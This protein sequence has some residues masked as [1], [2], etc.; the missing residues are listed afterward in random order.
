V[1]SFTINTIDYCIAVE[2]FGDGYRTCL[3]RRFLYIAGVA[4]EAAAGDHSFEIRVIAVEAGAYC[5]RRLI[6][7]A[8]PGQGE[9]EERVLFP[10]GI[11]L[12]FPAGSEGD[13][14]GCGLYSVIERVCLCRGVVDMMGLVGYAVAGFY[15]YHA[16]V[17]E[18]ERVFQWT[19]QMFKASRSPAMGVVLVDCDLSGMA[20]HAGL[21]TRI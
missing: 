1:A 13:V 20:V 21:A 14:E 16:G 8:I 19:G 5:P 12:C 6:G 7:C 17:G 9:F 10:A 11:G 15:I 18:G 3:D 4:F 2:Y